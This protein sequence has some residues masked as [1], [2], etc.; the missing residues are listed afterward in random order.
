[1]L[2][3]LAR[4]GLAHALHHAATRL[5]PEFYHPPPPAWALER[6]AQAQ[7]LACFVQKKK[8]IGCSV[9]DSF[10]IC[11]NSTCASSNLKPSCAGT[12]IGFASSGA[13]SPEP[14]SAKAA[15]AA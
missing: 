14:P 15:G 4:F 8:P 7:Q 2:I 12:A 10:L 11:G 3:T 9:A 6:L 5:A 1:M 13:S